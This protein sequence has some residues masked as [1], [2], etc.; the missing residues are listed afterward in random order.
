MS[1]EAPRPSGF[2]NEALTFNEAEHILWDAGNSALLNETEANKTIMAHE[3]GKMYNIVDLAREAA[4]VV[5]DA[6]PVGE[7]PKVTI[8]SLLRNVDEQAEAIY[9]LEDVRDENGNPF[10]IKDES[11]FALE[12][13]RLYVE[14]A[15]HKMRDEQSSSN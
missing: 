11:L 5:K 14:G 3:L 9:N 12:G 13:L 4:D 7:T 1:T 10:A 15:Y 6:L 8:G 2:R